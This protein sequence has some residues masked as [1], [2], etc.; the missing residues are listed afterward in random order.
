VL[1][2]VS[3]HVGKKGLRTKVRPKAP[4]VRQRRTHF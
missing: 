2:L 3:M 4:N 1:S